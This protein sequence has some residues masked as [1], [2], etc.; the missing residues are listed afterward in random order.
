MTLP[1]SSDGLLVRLRREA[2]GYGWTVKL[3]TSLDGVTCKAYD[4]DDHLVAKAVGHTS[5]VAVQGLATV[6]HDDFMWPP[7]KEVGRDGF[8]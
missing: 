2:A 6:L 5:N 3:G 1:G 8:R 4:E 7:M